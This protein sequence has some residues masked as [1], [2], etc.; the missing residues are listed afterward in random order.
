MLSV[1]I[2]THESER[3]LVPT[4]AALV[5]GATAGLVREVIV[6]D[7]G[8]RDATAEVADIAGCRL[9]VAPG[10][11]AV[12]LAQATEAARALWLLFL[13]AGAVPQVG[14]VEEVSRFTEE[15]S[16]AGTAG[17][18][19]AVFRAVSP[20]I[21]RASPLREGLALVMQA[22]GLSRRSSHGLLISKDLYRRMGQRD[23][24]TV[25]A[26][27]I[28][29]VVRRLGRRHIVILRCGAAEA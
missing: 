21:M 25:D 6:A 3:A 8:S 26:D 5:P 23:A 10:P 9:L 24:L 15:T 16:R 28:R 1:I 20:S 7:A 2:A 11:L 14:W 29:A 18:T 19:A 27:V 4:L 13:K 12:R 17:T 22:A